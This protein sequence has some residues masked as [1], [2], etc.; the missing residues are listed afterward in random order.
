MSKNIGSLQFTPLSETT[1]IPSLSHGSSPPPGFLGFH[2]RLEEKKGEEPDCE[3]RERRGV[4][5]QRYD[6]QFVS[7][8]PWSRDFVLQREGLKIASEELAA[9]PATCP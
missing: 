9:G 1:S 7:S 2:R 8:C 6:G 4:R 5:E 3:Q